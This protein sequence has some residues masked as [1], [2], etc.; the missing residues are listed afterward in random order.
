MT[1][2]CFFGHHRSASSWTNDTL[3]MIAIACGWR[4]TVVHNAAMFENDLRGFC[5]RTEPDLLTFSNAKWAYLAELPP[6]LGLHVIR[7]PRDVL[8]SSYFSHRNSHSTAQWPA[9]IHHRAELQQ[10]SQAEGL[11]LE[12]ECRR[13]QFADMA[14]WHYD[15]D[16][17]Y[18]LKMEDFTEQPAYYYTDLFRFWQRLATGSHPQS[19]AVSITINRLLFRIERRLGWRTRLPRWRAEVVWPWLLQEVVAGNTFQRKSGGRSAGVTDEYHHYREGV[20][21]SWRRYFFPELTARFKANY[22][23]LL[24]QVGY[25]TNEEW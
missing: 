12:L 10:L 11:L 9:L 23:D 4:H 25:E 6:F 22:N 2:L 21:G 20:H 13:E 24:V 5:Q 17:I 3:Q 7:D 16:Q 1:L 8:V 19:A 14:A 18:E 15:T